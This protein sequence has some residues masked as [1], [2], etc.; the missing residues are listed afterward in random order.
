MKYYAARCSSKFFVKFVASK[1]VVNFKK[2]FVTNFGGKFYQ[3]CLTIDLPF[4]LPAALVKSNGPAIL[5]KRF[6]CGIANSF[7]KTI[8][9]RI[10]TVFLFFFN[11]F[12]QGV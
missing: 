3:L 12:E 10:I 8:C 4:V 6:N 2:K 9:Q 7:I 1:F 5:F 11:K